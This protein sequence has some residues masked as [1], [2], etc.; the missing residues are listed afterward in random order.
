MKLSICRTNPK[1]LA[2]IRGLLIAVE[3]EL[4]AAGPDEVRSHPTLRAHDRLCKRASDYLA[5]HDPKAAK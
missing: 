2:L 4:A 5:S 1:A 3:E